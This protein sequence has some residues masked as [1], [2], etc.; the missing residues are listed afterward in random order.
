M[1]KLPAFQF[2]PGDYLKDPQVT[3]LS[4]AAR[5]AWVDLICA[6]HETDRTGELVGSVEQM[7][8]ITRCSVDEFRVCLV[9]LKACKVANITERN[10]KITIVNRR[11]AREHKERVSNKMR[12]AKFR[13]STNVVKKVTSPS[14]SS[15]S[16]SSSNTVVAVTHDP[17]FEMFRRVAGQHINNDEL[18]VE[19]GKFRNKYPNIH[20]NQAGA[21]INTWVGNIGK[22]QVPV[23]RMVL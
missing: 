16:S 4:L 10:G 18:R 6:M 7:A 14:S 12:Q 19:I 17:W 9:E 21:L 20:P 23:K 22:E 13:N 2:Y 15:S 5:G 3:M 11:M 8:R 1:S